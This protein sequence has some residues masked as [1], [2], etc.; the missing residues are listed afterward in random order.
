MLTL[1]CFTVYLSSRHFWHSPCPVSDFLL[2]L[3][4]SK[5]NIVVMQI[6]DIKELLLYNIYKQFA[7]YIILNFIWDFSVCKGK[8]CFALIIFL[9]RAMKNNC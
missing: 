8:L 7:K 9:V 4:R 3:S 2:K 6:R 1:N 5:R